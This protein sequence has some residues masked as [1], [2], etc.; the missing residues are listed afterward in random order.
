M[1]YK[2]ISKFEKNNPK[3][4]VNV[5]FINQKSIHIARRSGFNSKRSKQVKLLMITVGEKRHYTAVK[6]LS[7]LLKSLNA[8]HSGAYHFCVN[9]L[10]AFRTESV[11]D[12]HYKYCSS[13]G[14]VNVKM[15]S[16]K[17]KW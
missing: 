15:P 8:K 7:R 14:E 1:D 12:K 5:M 3:I 10:N 2:R 4:A 11:R 17:D 13:H 6:N 9:C 16:E